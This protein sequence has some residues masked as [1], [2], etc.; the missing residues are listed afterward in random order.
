M[1]KGRCKLAR[2]PTTSS[3]SLRRF[4]KLTRLPSQGR[5][6][7]G[8]FCK[9]NITHPHA[10]WNICETKLKVSDGP[11]RPACD[12]SLAPPKPSTTSGSQRVGT[13]HQ[14]GPIHGRSRKNTS[15]QGNE[16]RRKNSSKLELYPWT[17]VRS[18]RPSGDPHR[19]QAKPAR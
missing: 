2:V 13:K 1:I 10:T 19:N 16:T 14:N 7:G 6:F 18:V 8:L 15:L 4:G 5:D 9:K 12:L 17:F 3:D 11:T